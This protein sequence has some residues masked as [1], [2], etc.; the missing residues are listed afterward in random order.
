MSL[1]EKLRA[2]QSILQIRVE[3]QKDED[4]TRDI[5][6]NMAANNPDLET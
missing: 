4:V 1:E 6:R 3:N 5:L 2:Y